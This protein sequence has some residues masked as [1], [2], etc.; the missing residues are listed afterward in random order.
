ML[1]PLPP[2]RLQL[3]RNTIVDRQAL[4]CVK[5]CPELGDSDGCCD[6]DF[7]VATNDINDP[8]ALVTWFQ[9]STCA[10]RGAKMESFLAP[11]RGNYLLC[12]C[13]PNEPRHA[14]VLPA[15]AN[16]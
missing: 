16:P 3:G 15:R 7:R 12:W 10:K 9:Q 1:R 4:S 13:R 2:L 5:F 8:R 6:T 14:D 11:L